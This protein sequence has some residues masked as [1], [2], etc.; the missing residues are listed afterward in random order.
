[1]K[2]NRLFVLLLAVVICL[3]CSITVYASQHETLSLSVV[4]EN[5]VLEPGA[6]F[7]VSVMLDGNPGNLGVNFDVKWDSETV[8]LVSVDQSGSAFENVEANQATSRLVVTIANPL[9]GIMS[10][11]EAEKVEGTGMVLDITFKSKISGESSGKITIERASY[12]MIGG[13]A[14]NEVALQNLAMQFVNA[15]HTHTPGSATC[16]EEQICTVCKAVVGPKLEHS[17]ETVATQAANCGKFGWEA[18]EKC[19]NCSYSTMVQIKPT[20][21]H[22]FGGWVT[23]LEATEESAG[24]QKRTCTV[25]PFAEYRDTPED[26]VEP[27]QDATTEGNGDNNQPTENGQPADYTPLIIVVLGV[28]VA[29]VVVV[30][31]VK[32]KK[33]SVDEE[34]L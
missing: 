13:N 6:T 32:K 30:F 26:Y 9:L 8:E 21:N 29:A 14:S 16:T 17:L 11:D 23:V 7:V 12:V 27:T 22:T 10:P 2:H 18:Y 3:C 28:L 5:A 19:R 31:L 25:C 15:G 34:D 24:K 20:G 33:V 1:M 4:T